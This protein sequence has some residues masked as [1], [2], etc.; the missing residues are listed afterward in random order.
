MELTGSDKGTG[1]ITSG[2][3]S[4]VPSRWGD[5]GLLVIPRL[6]VAHGAI[7]ATTIGFHGGCRRCLIP[8]VVCTRCEEDGGQ[9]MW[10][11]IDGQTKSRFG[12]LLQIVNGDGRAHVRSPE[13]RNLGQIG[14][15]LAQKAR[16]T[17]VISRAP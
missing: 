10:R 17:T 13:F 14:I 15:T 8:L 2:E 12:A 3:V 6:C 7:L 5:D 9:R 4:A 11:K 16:P 1:S